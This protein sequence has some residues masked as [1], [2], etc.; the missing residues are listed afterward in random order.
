MTYYFISAFFTAFLLF[1]KFEIE[2]QESLYSQYMLNKFLINPAFAGAEGFTSI[3]LSARKNWLGYKNAPSTIS[4]SAHTRV[5][6]KSRLGKSLSIKRKA[7]RRKPRGRVGFGGQIYTDKNGAISQTG[8][9][10]TYSYHIPIRNSQLS[11]GITGSAYQFKIN[12]DMLTTHDEDPFI[13]N[14][15]QNRILPD[16][17]FGV[18]Y[19]IYGYYVGYSA[20]KLFGKFSEFGKS[21]EIKMMTRRSHSLLTGYNYDFDN[22]FE[23]EGSLLLQYYEGLG[24]ESEL[25]MKGTYLKNYWLGMSYR[26]SKEMV[27]FVGGGYQ[28]FYFGYSFDYYVARIETFSRGS[29]EIFAGYRFGD[30]RRRYRW[31]NR[32]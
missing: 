13:T 27:W 32:F 28:N 21:G 23:V 2:A 26:T 9:Q 1:N 24:F 5:L 4:V 11:F 16:A 22:D 17:S 30:N 31:L 10:G 3:N 8:L 6:T 14:L 18:F 25:S 29:H 20:S 15:K 19:T 7:R 12:K